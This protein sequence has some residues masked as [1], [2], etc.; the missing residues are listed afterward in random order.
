MNPRTSRRIRQNMIR[1]T[2]RVSRPRSTLKRDSPD[3]FVDIMPIRIINEH[4]QMSTSRSSNIE[5]SGWLTSHISMCDTCIA[6]SPPFPTMMNNSHHAFVDIV[7]IRI[8]KDFSDVDT[9]KQQYHPDRTET[10]SY[11][12]TR[13]LHC[14]HISNFHH[15]SGR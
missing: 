2:C 1:D 11:I 8:I 7:Q 4:L 14:F 13:H 12:E 10:R 3:I 6:S 15:G 9:S 5:Y